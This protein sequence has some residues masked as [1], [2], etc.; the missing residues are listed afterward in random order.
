MRR[1]SPSIRDWDGDGPR[2]D[3]LFASPRP[4]NINNGLISRVGWHRFWG[5]T[6][7]SVRN[8]EIGKAS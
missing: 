5:A 6:G 2:E 8:E 4:A 1:D 3:I 7:S